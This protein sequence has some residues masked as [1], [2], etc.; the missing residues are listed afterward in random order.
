MSIN[1]RSNTF[2]RVRRESKSPARGSVWQGW[3]INGIKLF[4]NEPGGSDPRNKKYVV[5]AASS[6]SLA[7]SRIGLQATTLSAP[8]YSQQRS[9]LH[10]VPD[11]SC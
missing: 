8:T 5:R 7:C 3:R 1:K 9:N 11:G 10:N 6:Y 2:P 4:P